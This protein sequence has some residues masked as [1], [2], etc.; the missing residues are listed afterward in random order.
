MEEQYYKIWRWD[1]CPKDIKFKTTLTHG[2]W[3]VKYPIGYSFPVDEINL[4]EH[5]EYE[6]DLVQDGAYNLMFIQDPNDSDYIFVHDYDMFGQGSST[7]PRIH[8]EI[9]DFKYPD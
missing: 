8:T 5:P 9:M 1:E 2:T 7:R 6:L 3:V 4:S